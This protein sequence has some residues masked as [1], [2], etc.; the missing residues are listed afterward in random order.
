M[1]NAE[2]L[3]YNLNSLFASPS[4]AGITSGI[5]PANLPK[6]IING[7]CVE[8][9]PHQRLPVNT[10][11]E[12]VHAHGGFTAYADKHPAYE[13][14]SG[15]SGEGLDEGYFPEINSIA[16]AAGHDFTANVDLAITWDG[17]HVAAWLDWIDGITP[18]NA[19]VMRP[20]GGNTP[21]LF[22][23]NFQSVSVG[24]KTQGYK[25][26]LSFT[27]GLLKALDFVDSSLGQ[28]V[29]KL[30][31]KGIYDDTLIIIASKHGQAPI[32]PKLFGKVDPDAVTK[33][34]DVPVLFNTVSFFPLSLN[35]TN[36][37]NFERR[38]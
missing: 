12:V 10:V 6:K 20:L 34:T 23:G 19:S 3:D 2:N 14:V 32:N 24:Q 25:S 30:K 7:K 22:G 9:F 38:R 18:T 8:V 17:L 26:D 37:R 11:F 21:T 13:L 31:D 27:D 35:S 29:K 5:D 36:V 28:I 15:P 4:T 1:A 33:D 16:D